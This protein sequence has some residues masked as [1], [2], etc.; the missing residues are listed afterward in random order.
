MRGRT[1]FK[2]DN[3][4]IL[5]FPELYDPVNMPDSMVINGHSLIIDHMSDEICSEE[6]KNS[7]IGFWV[8]RSINFKHSK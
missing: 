7:A 1:I 4:I 3:K 2:L 8:C 6:S 5:Q